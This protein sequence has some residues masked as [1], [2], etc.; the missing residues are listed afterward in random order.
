MIIA[1]DSDS[2]GQAAT[3]RGLD[4]LEKAGC[5]IRVLIIPDGKDPDDYIR[6][7]GPEKFKN[8]VDRAIS[9][10]DYK[11]RAEKICTVWIQ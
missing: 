5:N 7:N 6:N 9:L 2:A 11:I 4:I 10:L 1:Y 3:M 8:L